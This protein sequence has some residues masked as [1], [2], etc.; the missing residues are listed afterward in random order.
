MPHTNAGLAKSLPP[1]DAFHAVNRE[2]P[3]IQ[4]MIAGG[5]IGPK[6]KGG[7]YR[8]NRAGGGKLKEA[9]DLV[10]GAYRAEQKRDL[11]ELAGASKDLRALLSSPG[12][13]GTYA[14]RVLGRTLSYAAE[15]VPDAADD[16]TA[17]DEAMRLGYNW[18]W[19]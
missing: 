18:Q 16:I 5:Y 4:K 3:L 12:K 17:I 15:L 13:I 1:T 19:G 7:F 9:I 11:P 2:L 10:S 6:G 14:W 8:L